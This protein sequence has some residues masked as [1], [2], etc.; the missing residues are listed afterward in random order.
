MLAKFDELECHP[1]YYTRIQEEVQMISKNGSN[2]KLIRPWIYFLKNFRQ[3]LLAL[4]YLDDYSSDGSHG[5][6]YVSRYI[7][8]TGENYYSDVQNV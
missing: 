1:D 2:G 4:P 8:P 3:E 7:R 6:K 5:L